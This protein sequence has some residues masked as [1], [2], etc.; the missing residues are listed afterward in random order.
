MKRK[1]KGATFF[2]ALTGGL[3]LVGGGLSYVMYG[4]YSDATAK[5]AKLEKEIGDEAALHAD[6]EQSRTTLIEGGQQLQHLELG[7]S[8]AEFIPTLLKNL[9]DTGRECELKV[10]G[11]KPIAEGSSKS[12]KKVTDNGEEPV[13]QKKKPYV[14]LEI[15]VKAAGM[16]SHVMKFLKRLEDFPKI[17]AVRSI[18]ITPKIEP[19]GLTISRL[20]AVV[21]LRVFVFP[22]MVSASNSNGSTGGGA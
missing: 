14:E 4:N 1:S 9:E 19:D 18:S 8:T 5:A 7:V 17:V 10:I 12:K 20:E 3:L 21:N 22:V 15:E 11:V 6:L 2:M 16:F 13:K